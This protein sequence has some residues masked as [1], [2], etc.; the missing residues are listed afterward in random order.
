M[1]ETKGKGMKM[2]GMEM[3]EFFLPFPPTSEPLWMYNKI[4]MLLHLN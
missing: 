3:F 4:I 1:E 2:E